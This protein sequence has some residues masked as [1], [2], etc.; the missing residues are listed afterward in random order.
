MA[1][2]KKRDTG[3]GKVVADPESWPVFEHVAQLFLG[4]RMS[5]DREM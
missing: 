3:R 4:R 5:Q 1:F 2:E